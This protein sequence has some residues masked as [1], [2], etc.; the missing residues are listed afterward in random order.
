MQ[1]PDRPPAASPASANASSTRARQGPDQRIG[2]AAQNPRL[3]MFAHR[4][5]IGRPVASHRDALRHAI[6][7]I[8]ILVEQLL[9]LGEQGLGPRKVA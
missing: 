7:Q 1:A 6:G 3:R 5:A 4:L 8:R 2:F 9:R